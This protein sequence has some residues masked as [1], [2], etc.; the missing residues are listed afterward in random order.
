MY[1]CVSADKAWQQGLAGAAVTEQL[2]GKLDVPYEKAAVVRSLGELKFASIAL[3]INYRELNELAKFS[4]WCSECV[5][6]ES[7]HFVNSDDSISRLNKNRVQKLS[8]YLLTWR[9]KFESNLNYVPDG[10]SLG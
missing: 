2:C 6:Y 1:L 8:E 7:F 3:T 9:E 10:M 4:M 5:G